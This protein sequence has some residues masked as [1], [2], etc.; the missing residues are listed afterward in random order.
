VPGGYFAV[1]QGIKFPPDV[2]PGP[3]DPGFPLGQ[4][5]VIRAEIADYGFIFE[6]FVIGGFFK[7]VL[8]GHGKRAENAENK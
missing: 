1:N 3:A 2:L 6:F 4:A 8:P 7:L 5:A